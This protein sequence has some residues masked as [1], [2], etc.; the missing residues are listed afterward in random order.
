MGRAG[1]DACAEQVQRA[2]LHTG[3]AGHAGDVLLHQAPALPRRPGH[4]AR[5]VPSASMDCSRMW[6]GWGCDVCDGGE[7]VRCGGDRGWG[8]AGVRVQGGD[9][10]GGPER[11]GRVHEEQGCRQVRRNGAREGSAAVCHRRP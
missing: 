10:A 11:A 4:G 6:S 7:D 5:T 9:E 1:A 8:V 2:L 3:V